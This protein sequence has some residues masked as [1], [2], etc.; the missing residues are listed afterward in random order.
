MLCSCFDR[1]RPIDNIVGLKPIDE[2]INLIG[3]TWLY[4]RTVSLPGIIEHTPTIQAY[5]Y[6][7]CDKDTVIQDKQYFVLTERYL[8]RGQIDTSM[9][10]SSFFV[11]LGNDSVIILSTDTT[12]YS[13]PIVGLYKKT[14]LRKTF[15]TTDNIRDKYTALLLP[16]S[17]S[18]YWYLR[19]TANND[20]NVKRRCVGK[21]IVSVPAGRYECYKIE[22]NWADTWIDSFKLSQTD[23]ITSFGLIQSNFDGGKSTLSNSWGDSLISIGFLGTTKLLSYSLNLPENVGP[24]LSPELINIVKT[25]VKDNWK[26]ENYKKWLDEH[27][28]VNNVTNMDE[29]NSANVYN[30]TYLLQCIWGDSLT[31]LPGTIS[32]FSKP[33]PQNSLGFHDYLSFL[34]MVAWE[35]E[36]MPG[37]IDC[38]LNINSGETSRDTSIYKFGNSE[39]R[40]NLMDTLY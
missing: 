36:M 21:E 22:W 23:W 10:I 6:I 8:E 15:K 35:Y 33:F 13:Y 17:D 31:D 34:Q 26:I 14:A 9:Y 20:F 4:D 5:S 25:T 18:S 1:D 19:D 28:K 11:N 40:T 39:I 30:V 2:N 7:S 37:W 24:M 16:F 38:D 29:L 27:I 12:S 32:E 3:R